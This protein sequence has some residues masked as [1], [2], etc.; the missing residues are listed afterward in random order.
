MLLPLLEGWI[1]LD[2]DDTAYFNKVL[3]VRASIWILGSCSAWIGN[4]SS[5]L[6]I[7]PS[8]R[9]PLKKAACCVFKHLHQLNHPGTGLELKDRMLSAFLEPFVAVF[10]QEKELFHEVFYDV[11]RI[12]QADE[13]TISCQ[14]SLVTALSGM[15]D[16]ARL[17][18]ILEASPDL[19]EYA[20]SIEKSLVSTS[21][22]Q[23]SG[24]LRVAVELLSSVADRE[25]EPRS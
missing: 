7:V 19:I 13:T 18:S 20:T 1:Q 8:L 15:I 22:Q 17:S 2:H 21:A 23:L 3:Q 16:D 12:I 5:V 11:S 25:A 24:R 9:V 6:E 14:T 4:D 10:Q